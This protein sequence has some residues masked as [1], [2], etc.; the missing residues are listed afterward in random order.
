MTNYSLMM[1]SQI[2]IKSYARKTNLQLHHMI[3]ISSNAK[4]V[5]QNG[6]LMRTLIKIVT[7]HIKVPFS[8]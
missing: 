7:T 2:T 3:L 4:Q 5:K 1:V 8:N 6:N